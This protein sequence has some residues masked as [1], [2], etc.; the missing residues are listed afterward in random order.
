MDVD[1]R[2]HETE[3]HHDRGGVDEDLHDPDEVGVLGELEH[4]QVDLDQRQDLKEGRFAT[5]GHRALA[6]VEVTAVEARSA[7]RASAHAC[8]SGVALATLPW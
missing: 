5:A 7:S 1:Q 2:Q 6:S 4:A 3:Q 8:C